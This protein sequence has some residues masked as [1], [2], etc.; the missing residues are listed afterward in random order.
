MK[1]KIIDK[2]IFQE[3]GEINQKKKQC[4]ITAY[5]QVKKHCHFFSGKV[6]ALYKG[7]IKHED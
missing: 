3:A 4:I 5:L 2:W 1:H 6:M 7:V